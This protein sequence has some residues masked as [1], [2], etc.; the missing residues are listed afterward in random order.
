MKKEGL[1]RVKVA[2]TNLPVFT[3]QP[4]IPSTF[5]GLAAGRRTRTFQQCTLECGF[6]CSFFEIGARR[7]FRIPHRPMMS[8]P[9]KLRQLP[10]IFRLRGEVLGE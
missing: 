5:P 3:H 4:S 2:I 1:Q 10:V 9:S 7:Q 8:I 6:I